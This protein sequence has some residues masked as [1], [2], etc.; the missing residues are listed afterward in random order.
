MRRPY[1]ITLLGALFI[2]GSLLGFLFLRTRSVTG[3]MIVHAAW[4]A[5]VFV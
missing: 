3:C 1:F 5:L 2:L 4:N